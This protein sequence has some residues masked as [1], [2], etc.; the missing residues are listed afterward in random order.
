LSRRQILAA[1]RG[2]KRGDFSTRLPDDLT[3]VDGQIAE[4]F[5]AILQ[6]AAELDAEL[7]AVR[8]AVGREGRTRRRAR[9]GALRGG[10]ASYV[11]SVDEMLDA[12]TQHAEEMARVVAAV[13]LGDLRQRIDIQGADEPLA[14]DFLRHARAV[15]GMV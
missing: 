3:G 5:N 12:V 7:G 14:G 4:A 1:L 15:N 10:W 6:Q 13:S 9:K 8:H 11:R 2:L